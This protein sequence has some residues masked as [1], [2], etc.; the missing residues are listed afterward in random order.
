M[1]P[2]FDWMKNISGSLI[3]QTIYP[4]SGSQDPKKIA[5]L[6][7]LKKEIRQRKTLDVPFDDLHITVVDIETTG[8]YPLKGDQILSIGAQKIRNNRPLENETFYTLIQHDRPLSEEIQQ[9]TGLSE[10][11][12]Q[13]APEKKHA[14]HSFYS[15]TK[16]ETLA[17]HHAAHEKAFLQQATWSVY[18]TGFPHRIVDTV[19][20]TSLISDLKQ[21]KDLE[22]CCRFF[23]IPLNGRHHALED[24]K[25]AASLWC[26]SVERLKKDGFRSLSDVYRYIASFQR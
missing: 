13:S 2:L 24:A 21:L 1:N 7:H 17:A 3:D 11:E 15:F 12:L 22:D 23:Q 6:R 5:Y 25:M 20:L 18:K 4:G 10:R 16:E 9:L 26:C 19:L 8:F 14:L